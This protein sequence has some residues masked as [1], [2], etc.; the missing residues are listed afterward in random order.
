MQ[1]QVGSAMPLLEA[2]EHAA[3][4]AGVPVD[5]RIES[6]RSPVHALKRLWESE[7]FDRIV[8]P[9]P[10]GGRRQGFTPKDLA[11]MLTHAPSETL[12]LRPD[13]AA[14][15][16]NGGSAGGRAAAAARVLG[17]R[18]RGRRAP[19]T[20]SAT[21]GCDR[22]S[23]PSH[24]IRCFYCGTE[25]G[26][27]KPMADATDRLGADEKAQ[28]V[29]LEEALF[30]IR[31]VIAGQEGMLERL[32]VCLLAGGHLLIEGVPGLAKTLAIKTTASVLGGSFA[33]IQFT[34]DLVPSDLVGTRI[35]RPDKH[36]FETEL[37]P[38]FCNFLLAD[39][40]NRA[41]AK[42]QSALLEVMQERQVTIGHT[43]HPVPD[44][45]LV[46]ATQ[47][48][49]ESE[50][51]YPLPEAQVDRFM[52]KVL[53][54]YPAHDEELTVVARSL[55]PAVSLAAGPLD[56]G[57][58][59]AAGDG[60]Q[61]LRR[62]G[63][64]QLGRRPRDRHPQ[65]GRGRARGDRAVH[66][67]RRQPA[68]ADQ[69]HRRRPR[70]RGA[71]PARL[72]P[73]ER[74]RGGRSRRVPPPARPLLPG[75]RG[76]GLRR[77]GAR[78]GPGRGRTAADRS[79]TARRRGG[80]KGLTTAAARER[81]AARPGP[82][83]VTAESL[84][85]LELA[86]GRRVDG[87]LAGDYRSAFAGVGTELYQVRPYEAG[88]DVRRIDWN[89]TARTGQ[90]HVRVELAER[91]LVTW[92]VFDASASMAFGTAERRKADVAEGVALAVGHAAT[93][94]GNRLGLVAFGSRRPPLAPSPPGPPRPPADPGGAAR[95]PGRR[96][97]PRRGARPARR[98]RPASARSS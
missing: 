14:P 11:W 57:P 5:A 83:A 50:G 42:V 68:R 18:A 36:D 73:P 3:L 56:R 22:K 65:A 27:S 62:S 85:A 71:P 58:E 28:L 88:D 26:G 86:I 24:R 52:L 69:R 90:T 67:L 93:R 51:T 76:R 4:R 43:T 48:P 15:G 6:G 87:L 30:E 84:E 8:V 79:R 77:S 98:D 33:R 17:P 19:G 89:V 66:L 23:H 97:R 39:E 35:F 13:P 41:P 74:C 61:G 82:G 60:R 96:R 78:P 29:K 37:G 94:R 80:V 59:G 25:T 1:Q 92:L 70:A 72:R 95:R 12:I 46:L 53:V 21:A 40:I 63:A 9:A 55:E 10:A 64:R 75:A 2:V 20:F 45:F 31:R 91:V 49:I 81:T 32:L 7:H 16:E 54:D 34:P 44:P 38:V 47:N